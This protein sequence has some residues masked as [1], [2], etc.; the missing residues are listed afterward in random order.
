MA[1]WEQRVCTHFEATDK[2]EYVLVVVMKPLDG[3]MITA[4]LAA[5]FV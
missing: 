4:L 2:P 5:C 1:Q 3:H